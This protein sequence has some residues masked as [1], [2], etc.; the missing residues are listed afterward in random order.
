LRRRGIFGAALLGTAVILG[1]AALILSS[2]RPAVDKGILSF[3]LVDVNGAPVSL[4]A[5]RFSGKVVLVDIWG[6]W[7]PPC[8]QQVPHLIDLQARYSSDGFEVVGVEFASYYGDDRAGYTAALRAWM[9]EQ[10]INYTIVQGGE[11]QDVEN[12]FPT[13]RGFAGFPT[14]MLI[15]RDGRVRQVT[16][17]FS[18]ADLPG[19]EGLVKKLLNEPAPSGDATAGAG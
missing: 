15:G 18:A 2:S 7:C 3:D 13:L 12:V 10:G 8:L 5:E 19:L 6:L 17:G 1:V 16:Q 11:T 14:S 9:A 4:T